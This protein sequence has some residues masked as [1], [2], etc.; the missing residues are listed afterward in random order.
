LFSANQV[1]FFKIFIFYLCY[2]SDSKL[3]DGKY[4]LEFGY[5]PL[6]DLL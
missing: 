4:S 2:S 3:A 6:L 5:R 1:Q